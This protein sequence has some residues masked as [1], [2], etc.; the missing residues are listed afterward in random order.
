VD[1]VMARAL[2]K[3][4]EYADTEKA[5]GHLQAF[6]LALGADDRAKKL[7]KRKVEKAA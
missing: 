6:F 3:N 2:S 7:N 1:Y 4:S 5:A